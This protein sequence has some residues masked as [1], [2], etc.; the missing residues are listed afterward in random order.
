MCHH[1]TTSAYP[2]ESAQGWGRCDAFDQPG[3]PIV[4]MHATASPCVLFGA[5]TNLAARQSFLKK[6][7]EAA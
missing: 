5:G 4:F 7:R 1:F 6:H 2:K 3:K